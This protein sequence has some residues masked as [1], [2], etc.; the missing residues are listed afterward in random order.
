MRYIHP[1]NTRVLKHIYENESI[2]SD[3]KDARITKDKHERHGNFQ[4][5]H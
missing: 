1:S 4:P 2:L 3:L 5:E